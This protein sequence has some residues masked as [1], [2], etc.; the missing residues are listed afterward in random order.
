MPGQLI[1]LELDFCELCILHLLRGRQRGSCGPSALAGWMLRHV[2]ETL[3]IWKGFLPERKGAE[4]EWR[5][6]G[7]G[8]EKT[9]VLEGKKP[10]QPARF[11]KK[12][13]ITYLI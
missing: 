5:G 2:N 6:V 8:E 3:Q 7:G 12:N 1:I 13:L 4:A 9:G 11:K 10:R